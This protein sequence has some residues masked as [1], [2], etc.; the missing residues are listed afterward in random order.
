MPLKSY[1]VLVGRPAERRREG[2]TDSPHYHIRID[3]GG[4]Q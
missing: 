2:G 1:G 4:A 3:P